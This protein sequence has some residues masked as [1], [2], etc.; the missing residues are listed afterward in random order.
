MGAIPCLRTFA[1]PRTPVPTADLAARDCS[2]LCAH[3]GADSRPR[4][5]GL[6][7]PTHPPRVL[8]LRCLGL[9]SHLRVLSHAGAECRP[10]LLSSV[11]FLRVFTLRRIGLS[12]HLRVPWH[13]SA[14]S[15]HP[16]DGHLP[17]Q[18]TCWK[19]VIGALLASSSVNASAKLLT[20]D[21]L[22][23]TLRSSKMPLFTPRPATSFADDLRAITHAAAQHTPSHPAVPCANGHADV[24]HPPRV[25]DIARAD[26]SQHAATSAGY[27]SPLAEEVDTI[28]LFLLEAAAAAAAAPPDFFGGPDIA[29][30]PAQG[31]HTV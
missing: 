4:S 27:G 12:S 20:L 30:P 26:F 23:Y 15:C 6:L 24:F 2:L 8:P 7:P 21:R 17:F 1:C 13:A 28:D 19:S 22:I 11:R 25:P 10:R 31:M 9:S 14:D 3:A 29:S 18:L 5:L 16:A